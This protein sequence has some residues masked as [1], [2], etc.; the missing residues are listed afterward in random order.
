MVEGRVDQNAAIVPGGALNPDR[1]V[2]KAGLLQRLVGNGDGVL[3]Q[4]RH[5]RHVSGPHHILDWG[6]GHFRDDL[7]LLNVKENDRCGGAEQQLSSASVEDLIHHAGGLERL[8]AV[9]LQVANGNGLVGL[10]QDCESVAGN[11]DGRVADS[12]LSFVGW[13]ARLTSIEIL[14]KTVQLVGAAVDS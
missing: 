6:S 12:A 2:D 7:A 4:Q 1:L 3:A 11:K 13:L 8:C 10:L 5:V 9:V 14:G